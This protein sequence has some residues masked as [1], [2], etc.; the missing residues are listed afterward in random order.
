M[1]LGEN[2][3]QRDREMENEVMCRIAAPIWENYVLDVKK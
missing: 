3:F 2:Q 1:V